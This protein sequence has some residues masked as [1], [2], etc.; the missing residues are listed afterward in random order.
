MP[1]TS[2]LHVVENRPLISPATLHGELPLTE[3]AA[4]LVAETRYRIRNILQNEDRRLL[5]ILRF[6][7]VA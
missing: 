7:Q 2:D 4:T 1:K 3:T 5:V 6:N